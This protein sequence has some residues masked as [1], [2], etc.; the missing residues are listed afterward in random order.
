ME[1]GGSVAE[2]FDD[3]DAEEMWFLLHTPQSIASIR[4]KLWA[5]LQ[6]H[7]SD[8]QAIVADMSQY[9]WEQLRTWM[10]AK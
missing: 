9:T 7:D 5:M 8:V 10:T 4:E 1:A 6:Y 3:V 2:H